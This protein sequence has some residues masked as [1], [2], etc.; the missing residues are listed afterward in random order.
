M[1]T[2]ISFI[3][4]RIVIISISIALITIGALVFGYYKTGH[5]NRIFEND[6]DHDYLGAFGDF[7]S[8][9]LGAILGIITIYLVYKTYISQKE[10]LELSRNLIQKQNF[11]STFFSLIDNIKNKIN[12][13]ELDNPPK[14]GNAVFF[15]LKIEFVNYYKQ[16][17]HSTLQENIITRVKQNLPA[18]S[19][20]TDNETQIELIR[21]MYKHFLLTKNGIIIKETIEEFFLI[22]EF[23]K[24]SEK[25]LT[26][27]KTGSSLAKEI[28]DQYKFYSEIL[29]SQFTNEFMFYVYYHGVLLAKT[30]ELIEYYKIVDNLFIEDLVDTIEHRFLYSGI[31]LKHKSSIFIENRI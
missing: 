20:I 7:L 12:S 4:K 8:G 3:E 18:D 13:L 1:K 5:L 19:S 14:K 15:H 29:R 22:L 2:L 6:I 31:N 30:K 27:D 25:T 17:C 26:N 24:K 28:T 16:Q 21:G 23:I 11:E 9:F 10:E